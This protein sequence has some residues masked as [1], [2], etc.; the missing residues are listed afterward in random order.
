MCKAIEKQAGTLLETVEPDFV[1]LLTVTGLASTPNG[2]AAITAYNAMVKAVLAWVPGT[3]AQEAIQVINDFTTI[4]NTLPLPE[5]VKTLA[6][7]VSAAVVG[8]IGVLTANSPAPEAAEAANPQEAEAVQAVHAHLVAADTQAKVTAIS[9][10]T[11]SRWDMARVAL[12]DTGAISGK[13]K[14][15]WKKAATQVAAV[16]PKYAALAA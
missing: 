2:Q 13:W 16:N 3:S 5:D 15:E 10:Y 11:P 8:V 6:S 1:Q 14:S 9:G 12:G 7:L 4:F